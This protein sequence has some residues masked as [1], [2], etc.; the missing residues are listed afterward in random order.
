MLYELLC[1]MW[2]MPQ[3]SAVAE[4]GGDPYQAWNYT[5]AREVGPIAKAFR[6]MPMHVFEEFLCVRQYVHDQYDLAVNEVV[7]NFRLAVTEMPVSRRVP[8]TGTS[9]PWDLG[10]TPFSFRRLPKDL[11][12]PVRYMFEHRRGYY[13]FRAPWVSN[14]ALLGVGFLQDFLLQDATARLGFFRATVPFLRDIWL[15]PTSLLSTSDISSFDLTQ[16]GLEVDWAKHDFGLN[17]LVIKDRLRAVG[18]IFWDS[19]DRLASVNLV[20][21]RSSGCFVSKSDF[22]IPSNLAQDVPVSQP[23]E[24]TDIE[25]WES[26]ARD[27]GTLTTQDQRDHIMSLFKPVGSLSFSEV[28]SVV[29][30][31]RD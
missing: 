26:I 15:Q 3:I 10:L 8:S 6:H 25:D 1:I 31:S 18:W 17:T 19:P 22:L 24:P 20:S 2:A 28:T 5:S 14:M 4:R 27:F 30:G 29:T 23:D 16:K 21:G 11:P 12:E 7:E 9:S 13:Y